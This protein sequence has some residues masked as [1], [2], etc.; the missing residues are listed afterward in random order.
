LVTGWCLSNL[1][2]E[3][4]LSFGKWKELNLHTISNFEFLIYNLAQQQVWQI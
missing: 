4:K 3:N 1:V 2:I